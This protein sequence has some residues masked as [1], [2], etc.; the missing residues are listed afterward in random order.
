MQ[1]K[2]PRRWICRVQDLDGAGITR[3][4]DL[5]ARGIIAGAV[6]A[7]SAPIGDARAIYRQ[8]AT[9]HRADPTFQIDWLE[10]E[11]VS[12]IAATADSRSDHLRR[13]QEINNALAGKWP[14][15]PDAIYR[16]ACYLTEDDAALSPMVADKTAD[17]APTTS[18][19]AEKG[20]TAD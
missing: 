5:D 11:L 19:N 2:R 15:D 17:V 3:L 20:A 4:P 6:S 7:A 18:S 10:A 8:L 12:S 1:A 13:V 9:E 14:K 16:L